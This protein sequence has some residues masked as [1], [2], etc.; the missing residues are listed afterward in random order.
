MHPTHSM[1]LRNDATLTELN[2]VPLPPLNPFASMRAPQEEDNDTALDRS[3]L[4]TCGWDPGKD[5]ADGTLA[6]RLRGCDSPQA[7]VPAR[8]GKGCRTEPLVTVPSRAD[9]GVVLVVWK[10]GTE[11]FKKRNFEYWTEIERKEYLLAK[12]FFGLPPCHPEMGL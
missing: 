3:P 6:G 12:Y 5:D 8:A 7:S 4:V 9:F 2:I 10:F 1:L 11:T